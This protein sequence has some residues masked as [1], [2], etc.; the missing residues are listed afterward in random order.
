M[1]T[2]FIAVAAVLLVQLAE[3]LIYDTL[4]PI[5]KMGGGY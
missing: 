5:A 3:A 4:L 1:K 2:F